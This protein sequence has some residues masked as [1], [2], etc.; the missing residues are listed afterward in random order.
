[1]GIPTRSLLAVLALAACF[2]H[3]AAGER[4]SRAWTIWR[5]RAGLA[6]PGRAQDV[7]LNAP[8]AVLTIHALFRASPGSHQV[9]SE[10]IV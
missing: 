6:R 2:L 1:M 9:P 8:R 5:D 4:P 7:P 3:G 10:P